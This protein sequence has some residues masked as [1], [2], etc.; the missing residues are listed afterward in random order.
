ML[1]SDVLCSMLHAWNEYPPSRSTAVKFKDARNSDEAGIDSP[2]VIISPGTTGPTPD[3]VPVK[4][5]SPS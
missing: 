1:E 3:G 2:A 4:M 5:R